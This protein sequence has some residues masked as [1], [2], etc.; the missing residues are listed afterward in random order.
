MSTRT[1][2]FNRGLKQLLLL[3]FLLVTTPLVM[4]IAF[5][6][7][8]HYQDQQIWIAYVLFG[9]SIVLLI[10]T[11]I[12]GFRTFKTILDALFNSDK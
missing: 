12:L 2:L 9:F 7:L 10:A 11:L 6:A 1:N 4:N 3:L 5:K 8:N